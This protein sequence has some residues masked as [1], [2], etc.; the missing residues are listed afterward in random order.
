[1]LETEA[2]SSL[3]VFP[4]RCSP[5]GL[6][7]IGLD[8]LAPAKPVFEAVPAVNGENLAG[9]QLAAAFPEFRFQGIIN[10]GGSA[11]VY[12]A[13]HQAL[14]RFVAVKI[15]SAALSSQAESVARF[16]R[17]IQIAGRLNHPGI[18]QTFDAGQRQGIW[19]LSMELLRGVDLGALSRAAGP[20]APAAACE[21]VRQAALALQYAHERGLVHRDIKPGNLMLTAGRD[22]LPTVRV[23]DF[24]LAS[25]SR[26]EC[27]AGELTISG[28]F[29][30]TVDYVAPEQIE[31]PRVVDARV[32]I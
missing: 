2:N 18:V 8:L 1:M 21:L 16:E 24:G 4:A 5:T 27:I 6:L 15:L 13:E 17:E 23:L 30:G 10:R 19:Y 25:L 3:G 22:G 28:E 14:K 7:A 20:M 9:P 29:L 12:C 31:N 11:V 26:S 32:A